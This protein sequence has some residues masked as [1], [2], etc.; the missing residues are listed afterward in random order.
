MEKPDAVIEPTAMGLFV[1]EVAAG[2]DR[3]GEEGDGE[4]TLVGGAWEDGGDNIG[5]SGMRIVE[6]EV[7]RVEKS[8]DGPEGTVLD[9]HDD[10][11]AGIA[12]L[13][14]TDGEDVPI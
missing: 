10:A 2:C 4:G 9:A 14:S 6:G 13:I 11:S 5:V 3:E 12:V 8:A 1:F 7:T